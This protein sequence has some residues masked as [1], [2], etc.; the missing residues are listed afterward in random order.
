MPGPELLRSDFFGEC[1][2]EFPISGARTVVF[3]PSHLFHPLHLCEK[4]AACERGRAL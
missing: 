1:R 3:I 4:L 2:A